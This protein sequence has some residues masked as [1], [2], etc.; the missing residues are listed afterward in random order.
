MSFLDAVTSINQY[1]FYFLIFLFLISFLNGIKKRKGILFIRFILGFFILAFYLFGWET[2]VYYQTVPLKNMKVT[3]KHI[4][5]LE[6]SNFKDLPNISPVIKQKYDKQIIVAEDYSTYYYRDN[7]PVRKI[8][9]E[10]VY[11]VVDAFYTVQHGLIMGSF[12]SYTKYFVL[13][14]SNDEVY[15][16]W[17]STLNKG[18]IE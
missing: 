12:S 15:V 16:I 6:M 10:K 18:E 5:M 7:P 4:E 17:D 3:F 8:P 11:T 9:K 2:R 14:D 1:S 13:K